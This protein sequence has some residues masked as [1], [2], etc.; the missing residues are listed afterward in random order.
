MGRAGTGVGVQ[1]IFTPGEGKKLNRS[2]SSLENFEII[3][4]E[5]QSIHKRK[6]N[7]NNTR[8]LLSILERKHTFYPYL[9]KTHLLCGQ[10]TLWIVSS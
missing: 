8:V 6:R 4:G 3:I 9:V 5:L 2:N 7:L 10:Q 1:T